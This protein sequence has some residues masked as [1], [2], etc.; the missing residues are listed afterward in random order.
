M[1]VGEPHELQTLARRRWPLGRHP[2][3]LGWEL[4]TEQLPEVLAI[5][6]REDGSV[7]GWVG[8]ERPGTLTVEAQPEAAEELLALALAEVTGDVLTIEVA[9]DDLA[10]RAAVTDRGFVADRPWMGMWRRASIDDRPV[11]VGRGCTIRAMH[12]DED[13]ARVDVHRRAWRPAELPWHPD[14]RPAV[15]GDAE[16]SFDLAGFRRARA[17]WGY[18]RELDLVVEA[19]D[20]ELV[21]CCTAWFDAALGVA[22]IE[23]LG[24]V[25]SHRRRGLAGALCLEVSARVA[26][27]G[28]R[29][30]FLN[31]GPRVEYPANHGAYAKA[32]FETRGRG[33]TWVLR[34]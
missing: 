34:R 29:E 30:V 5:R 11:E 33:A 17:T 1:T 7:S 22:E 3:G 4:A 18:E 13:H 9:T 23:P 24:I 8:V 14:H 32:G 6:R 21:G 27:R 26:E 12:A 19:P 25:P 2:G 10:L 15:P 20:G 28:G 31:V 16:S